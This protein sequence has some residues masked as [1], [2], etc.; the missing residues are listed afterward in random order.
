LQEFSY[1]VEMLLKG[2]P[3]KNS[4]RIP[5]DISASDPTPDKVNDSIVLKA[6]DDAR[7]DFLKEGVIDF[8]HQTIRGPTKE[9]QAKAIIGQPE[10][11]DTKS[12]KVIVSGFLFK[13]NPYVDNSIYPALKAGSRVFGASVGGRILR[14]SLEWDEKSARK[15]NRITRIALNHIAV[16]PAYKAV[17]PNTS[18]T[19]AKS[20]EEDGGLL[21]FDSFG[22]FAKSF[23]TV[24]EGTEAVEKAMMAGVETDSAAIR[25]GQ[26]L[27]PE[28]LEG[29]VLKHVWG[30]LL[31]DIKNGNLKPSHNAVVGWLVNRGLSSERAK[32]M[33]YVLAHRAREIGTTLSP[34]KI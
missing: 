8:D 17:H 27:Q 15:V 6:F 10:E 1:P 28:S 34:A 25:G 2:E 32:S 20:L 16:T 30:D 12:G 29:D 26:A 3:E 7:E 13:G 5:I 22:E 24:K 4:N 21:M 19:L 23:T 9:D 11:L 18:I 14:K 31:E 33:A